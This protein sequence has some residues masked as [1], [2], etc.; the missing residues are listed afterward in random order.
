MRLEASE[1]DTT[2]GVIKISEVHVC[3]PPPPLPDIALLATSSEKDRR[4]GSPPLS[5]V[6]QCPRRIHELRVNQ[7][8]QVFTAE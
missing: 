3:M 8:A 7:L 4:A 2:P 5:V 6:A 1:S